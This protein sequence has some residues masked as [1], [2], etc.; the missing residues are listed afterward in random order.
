MGD[1]GEIADF[2]LLLEYVAEI[3]GIRAHPLHHQP[4]ERVH[5]APDRGLRENSELVS[6]LHLPVQHGSDRILMAWKRGYTAMEYQGT[7]RKLRAIR[8]TCR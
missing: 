3:P 1:S 7:I 4:S 2:A 6:H 8:P 5:A